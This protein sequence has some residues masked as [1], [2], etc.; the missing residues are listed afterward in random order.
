VTQPPKLLNFIDGAFRAARAEAWLADICPATQE[1]IAQIPRSQAVDVADAVAAAAA[2]RDGWA[3][4]PVAERADYCDAIADGI[5]ARLD[6]LA[7]RE[8]RDTGK[9]IAQARGIDIPRAIANFRF[10]AAAVRGEST[11]PP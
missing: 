9:P 3:R 10:F 5:A 6:E 11:A 1:V 8:S 2:A 4:T 7:E